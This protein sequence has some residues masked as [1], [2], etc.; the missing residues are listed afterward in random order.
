MEIVIFKREDDFF[1]EFTKEISII[2]L[3]EKFNPYIEIENNFFYG[4]DSLEIV[5]AFADS[6]SLE[7]A[8][9]ISKCKF[10]IFCL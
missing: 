3:M 7:T 10:S 5:D 6:I 1:V 9:R 8:E 4:T 2:S